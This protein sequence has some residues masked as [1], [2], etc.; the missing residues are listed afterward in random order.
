MSR[1]PTG[2]EG[3]D[4]VIE[5]GLLPNRVYLVSGPPGS[6][7]TT[8]GA[9]FLSYGGRKAEVGLY[10][11]LSEGTDSIMEDMSRYEIMVPELVKAK[12]L[13][14]W[15]MGPKFDYSPSGKGSSA[16]TVS[17]S[18]TEDYEVP[19]PQ[20]VF[21]EI[22]DIVL[23]NNVKRLVIDSVSAIRFS[24]MDAKMEEK[25]LTKFIR[26][27]KKLGCTTLFLSELTN[28]NKYSIEHFTCHG[29]IFLHN[30]LHERVMVRAVQVVKMRGTSHD[31]E[32]RELHFTEKGLR[33]Y[34]PIK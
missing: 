19:S 7:K 31:C 29:V 26:N 25:E 34:G 2:V 18:E 32:M 27:L 14:F 33:V 3:F 22:K 17:M 20:V 4:D 8:F 11:S 16:V 28:P 12:R 13:I 6:G 30:F 10:V 9:Q 15:D 23:K 24:T 1:I 5:G 21:N